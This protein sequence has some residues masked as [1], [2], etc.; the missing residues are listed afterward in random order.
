MRYPAKITKSYLLKLSIPTTLKPCFNNDLERWN[1][2]NPAEPVTNIDFIDLNPN[3]W[4][5]TAISS[6]IK[7]L[8]SL[9][10]F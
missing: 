2:I 10:S 8:V 1:P 6:H 9:M 7:C 4:Q 3:I 5:E